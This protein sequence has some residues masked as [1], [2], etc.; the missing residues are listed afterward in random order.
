M[1]IADTDIFIAALRNHS[2]AKSLLEKYG[3]AVSLSA[4][5]AMEL[6]VGAKSAE[7]KQWV[8]VILDDHPWTGR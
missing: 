6:Y 2:I 7:K 4:V 3:S 5:T 1:V 8:A